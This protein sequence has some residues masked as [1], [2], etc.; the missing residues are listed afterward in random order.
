MKADA[1]L[2]NGRAGSRPGPCAAIC[3]QPT[4]CPGLVRPRP[5][6]IPCPLPQRKASTVKV[7]VI[8]SLPPFPSIPILPSLSGFVYSFIHSTDQ[9]TSTTTST[10]WALLIFSHTVV[11]QEVSG[12]EGE[13]V[14]KAGGVEH[15]LCQGHRCVSLLEVGE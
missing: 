8:A 14:L 7:S 4:S 10:Y 3:P 15:S 6:Q 13:G 11:H 2:R 9:P 1:V 5:C 12:P